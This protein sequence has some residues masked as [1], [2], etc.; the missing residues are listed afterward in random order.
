M[1]TADYV[2]KPFSTTDLAARIQAALRRQAVPV[3]DAPAEPYLLGD[4]TVDYAQRMVAVV[5]SPIDLTD[6][7]YRM[8]AELSANA[9]RV[10]TY[11]HLL[12]RVWGPEPP[13]T[14]DRCAPSS[15][16]FVTSPMTTRTAPGTSSTSRAWATAWQRDETSE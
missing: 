11:D 4:L 3:H 7:E 16:P 13:P 5:G 12:Q 14:R 10:L 1:G 6:I 8:L 9:D 2:V 15:R